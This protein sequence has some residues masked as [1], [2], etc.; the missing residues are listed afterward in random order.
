MNDDFSN[1]SNFDLL[2]YQ[3]VISTQIPAGITDPKMPRTYRVA[4]SMLKGKPL[5]N[6]KWVDSSLKNSKLQNYEE[7][8]VR[9]QSGKRKGKLI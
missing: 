8:Q 1:I 7:Y 2:I 6:K 9:Y 3:D 4:Y 5:I